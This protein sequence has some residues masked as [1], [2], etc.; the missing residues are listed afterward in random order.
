[1]TGVQTCALPILE[2]GQKNLTNELR[3]QGFL[4]TKV[5]SLKT[6]FSKSK[7]FSDTTL[8]IEEGPQT[9][10]KDIQF[11]GNSNISSEELIKRMSIFIG[12]PLQQNEIEASIQAIKDY[13]QSLGFLEM[14]ILNEDAKLVS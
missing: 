7:E 3:N 11:K 4:Q 12:G 10:I 6:S 14:R 9:L 1:M 13:Y 5:L 2:A 8:S